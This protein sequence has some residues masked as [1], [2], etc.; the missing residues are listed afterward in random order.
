MIHA[1]RDKPPKSAVVGDVL[2]G[3]F[4]LTLHLSPFIS[5]SNCTCRD[6]K[7]I[8]RASWATPFFVLLY[9]ASRGLSAKVGAALVA[10]VNFSS[11]AGRTGSGSVVSTTSTLVSRMRMRAGGVSTSAS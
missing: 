5:P 4:T 1:M 6:D 2:I 8:R 3:V 10:P 11:P 7:S 9:S